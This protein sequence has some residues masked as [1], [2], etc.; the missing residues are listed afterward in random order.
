MEGLVFF[1]N[2]L[3]GSTQPLTLNVEIA[4]SVYHTTIK[5][6]GEERQISKKQAL[7]M[8]KKGLIFTT[9]ENDIPQKRLDVRRIWRKPK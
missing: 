2:L 1:I 7:E 9:F 5:K 6:V 4:R 8:A 3:E